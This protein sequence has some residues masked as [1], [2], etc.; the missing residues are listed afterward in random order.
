MY[1]NSHFENDEHERKGEKEDV[2][3]EKG[4]ENELKKLV[5]IVNYMLW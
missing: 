1:L 5:V 3:G 4:K 2:W